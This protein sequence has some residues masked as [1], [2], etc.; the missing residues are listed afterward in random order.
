MKNLLI[1]FILAIGVNATAQTC[2]TVDIKESRHYTILATK[3]VKVEYIKG[4][5]KV[6]VNGDLY[7]QTKSYDDG[8][9]FYKGS[10]GFAV[11]WN[12]GNVM[13]EPHGS[14]LIYL[15]SDCN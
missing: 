3:K 12:N 8:T 7:T 9:K 6:Y 10:E 1:I 11:S 13:I 14:Q 15:Y 2:K 4:Y 5:K